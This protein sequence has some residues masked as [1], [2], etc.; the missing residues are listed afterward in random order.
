MCHC[1]NKNIMENVDLIYCSE[2]RPSWPET[3]VNSFNYAEFK[4]YITAVVR[5]KTF[6]LFKNQMIIIINYKFL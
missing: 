5:R 2:W 3:E 4:N 6:L 1:L